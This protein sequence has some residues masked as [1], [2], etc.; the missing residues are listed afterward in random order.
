MKIKCISVVLVVATLLIGCTSAPVVKYASYTDAAI[1]PKDIDGA[2]NTYE[3]WTTTLE[4]KKESGAGLSVTAQAAPVSSN[5]TVLSIT[6]EAKWY[7]TTAVT[8]STAPD[9][10]LL[11]SVGVNVTDNRAS[12]ITT[13]GELIGTLV[14]VAGAASNGPPDPCAAAAI[15]KEMDDKLA[16]DEVV[17][18]LDVITTATL[19][20]CGLA[21]QSFSFI[22]SDSDSTI[23]ELAEIQLDA[24]PASAIEY[25]PN[26][27]ALLSAATKVFLY[28]A[29]RTGSITFRTTGPVVSS[30]PK[31]NNT[32]PETAAIAK[33]A[34][35]PN[36]TSANSPD[37]FYTRTV[38]F[39]F[40]D[41][42]Y[43]QAIPLPVKGSLTVKAQCG[44]TA[45]A[46]T[47]TLD[48]TSPIAKAL[49]DALKSATGSNSNSK[50]P[51]KTKT[52]GGGT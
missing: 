10:N 7:K 29:C 47:G 17:N 50:A 51:T 42:R 21:R 16:F 41:P 18:L 2:L 19:K 6:G 3:L 4:F 1:A 27:A 49:A 23:G 34:T 13:A 33:P 28:P 26:S 32:K 15:P 43:V 5:P 44:M 31:T 8:L 24:P 38:N 48:S 52:T 20:P 37:M 25:G 46:D 40:S 36:N 12:Y 30:S 14:M 35:Q 45:G 9:S 39:L 22:V 11:T